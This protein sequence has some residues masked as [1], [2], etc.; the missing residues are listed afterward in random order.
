M[1]KRVTMKTITI[2]LRKIEAWI[3]QPL[4]DRLTALKNRSGHKKAEL[5]RR[6]V[7]EVLRKEGV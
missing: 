7:E 2:R 6:G 3:P 1:Y 4:Y 5:I